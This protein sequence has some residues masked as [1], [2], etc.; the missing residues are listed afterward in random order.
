MARAQPASETANRALCCSQ[1]FHHHYKQEGHAVNSFFIHCSSRNWDSFACTKTV[2][3]SP[4]PRPLH[5]HMVHWHLQGAAAVSCISLCK[6]KFG[7]LCFVKEE[8]TPSFTNRPLEKETAKW[9]L[10]GILA[11][12]FHL[13]SCPLTWSNCR[14]AVKRRQA[15]RAQSTLHGALNQCCTLQAVW[16]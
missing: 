4:G 15:Y 2:Y 14:E 13:W 9:Q 6:E 3:E 16:E 7:R 12:P 8:D 11:V 10:T 5:C 1:H